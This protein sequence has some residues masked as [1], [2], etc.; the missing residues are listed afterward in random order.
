VPGWLIFEDLFPTP[1]G[2]FLLILP[3]KHNWW[4]KASL[5]LVTA[6]RTFLCGEAVHNPG[7]TFHVPRLGCGNGRLDWATCVQGL[8]LA[9]PDNVVVHH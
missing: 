8:M 6:S 7:V 1:D 2:N 9:C 5:E 4:E 3:V